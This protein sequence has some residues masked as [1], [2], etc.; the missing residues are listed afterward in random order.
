MLGRRQRG[1]DQSGEPFAALDVIAKLVEARAGGGKEHDIAFVGDRDRALDGSVERSGGLDLC[2]RA[3]DSLRDQI[4]VAA[5]QEHGATHAINGGLE[6]HEALSF[7][8]AAGD[9][10]DGTAKA[11]E[12]RPRRGD[13]RALRIV[14]EQHAADLGDRV[15]SMCSP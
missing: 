3:G 1:A 15:H 5:D 13:R 2:R 7:A 12:R 9:Q 11:L 10:D 14:D 6:P 4:G 8:V